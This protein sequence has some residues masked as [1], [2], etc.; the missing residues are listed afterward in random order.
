M[1]QIGPHGKSSKTKTSAEQQ[2]EEDDEGISHSARNILMSP[3]TSGKYCADR[4]E[5][6]FVE[7][8]LVA[9][10]RLTSVCVFVRAQ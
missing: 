9:G 4:Q 6:N 1:G 7:G 5:L 8:V 2:E 3:K 10:R